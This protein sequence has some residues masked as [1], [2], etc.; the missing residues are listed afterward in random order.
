L[1]LPL[2]FLLGQLLQFSFLLYVAV[3]LRIEEIL[4]QNVK[5]TGT[6]EPQRGSTLA[7]SEFFGT[8]DCLAAFLKSCEI[9]MDHCLDVF[10]NAGVVN[11][12]SLKVLAGWPAQDQAEIWEFFEKEGVRPFELKVIKRGLDR[13]HAREGGW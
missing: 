5:T 13:L 1:F 12:E 10:K 7:D 3:R 2:L 11:M 6:R 9:A 8:V 4:T